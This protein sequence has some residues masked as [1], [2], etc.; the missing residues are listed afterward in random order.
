VNT[1]QRVADAQ[2]GLRPGGLGPAAAGK[3]SE[4]GAGGQA[5]LG[6]VQAVQ[7]RAGHD[8]NL[9]QVGSELVQRAR[10]YVH[11]HRRVTLGPLGRLGQ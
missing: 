3:Q 2:P 7:S 5:E 6:D 9:E 11:H 8:M 4:R 1:H 10:S